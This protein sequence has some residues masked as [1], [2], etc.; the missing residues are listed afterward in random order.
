MSYALRKGLFNCSRTMFEEI[1]INMFFFNCYG[2][3]FEAIIVNALVRSAE[4]GCNRLEHFLI[5][6]R[7]QLL[8]SFVANLK[9]TVS[10]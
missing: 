10:G 1:I 5:F 3:K 2:T 6:E 7:S 9:A 4:A 8:A